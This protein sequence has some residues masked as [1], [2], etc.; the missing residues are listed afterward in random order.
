MLD[1]DYSERVDRRPDKS[2]PCVEEDD[3]FAKSDNFHQGEYRDHSEN[4]MNPCE[5]ESSLDRSEVVDEEEFDCGECRQTDSVP[6]KQHQHKT[7][8]AE[9]SA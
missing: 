6:K 2:S 5:Y 7:S 8:N 9:V 4:Q 3:L 1:Y